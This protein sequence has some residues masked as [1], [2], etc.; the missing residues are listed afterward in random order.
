MED[1][2][3]ERNI[4]PNTMFLSRMLTG[5]QRGNQRMLDV[6]AS[7][8]AQKVQTCCPVTQTCDRSDP[9]RHQFLF[10]ACTEHGG[11]GSSELQAADAARAEE[12]TCCTSSRGANW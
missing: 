11:H 3:E 5:V 12:G 1:D 8:A 7:K 9:R 2:D 4:K 6:N 10:R